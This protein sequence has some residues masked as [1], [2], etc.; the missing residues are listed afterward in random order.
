MPA[1]LRSSRLPLADRGDA[2][3]R[4][5]RHRG[6]RRLARAPG[7]P[8]AGPGPRR[9]LRARR[10][11]R[12]AVR[13]WSHEALAEHG[14]RPRQRRAASSRSTSR[15][16]SP[17]STRL[18]PSWTSPPA[19]SPAERLLDET[20]RLAT[21]RRSSSAR[22]AAG[23]WPRVRHSRRSGPEGRLLV[24]KRKGERGHLRHRP[25]A[26]ATSTRRPSAARR[27]GSPSSASDPASLRWRTRRGAAPARP[28]PR[29]WSATASIS[30]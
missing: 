16:P 19:S 10:A 1:W 26:G 14:A 23:A 5:S 30:T 25:G 7:L 15:R 29:S 18:R 28:R 6:S 11:G 8:S 13:R 9:R 21:S 3:A 17:R 22:P 20:A 12:G 2:R 24:P 27:A 4:W